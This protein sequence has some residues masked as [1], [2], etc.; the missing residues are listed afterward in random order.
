[1]ICY[2]IGT[3]KT[4]L[5]TICSLTRHVH[6]YLLAKAVTRIY[7]QGMLGDDT[8]R[9]EGSKPETQRAEVGEVFGN[10]ALSPSPPARGM[11]E[12]CKLPQN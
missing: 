10:G 7:F 3:I 12:C 8:S 2:A 9:P 6:T 4:E 11:K 1:M 5:E